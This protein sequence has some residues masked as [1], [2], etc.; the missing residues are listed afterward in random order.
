MRALLGNVPTDLIEVARGT[1]FFTVP[2]VADGTLINPAIVFT[3]AEAMFFSWQ[4]KT[5]LATTSTGLSYTGAVY[6]AINYDLADP[7]VTDPRKSLAVGWWV[8]DPADAAFDISASQRPYLSGDNYFYRIILNFTVPS[9]EDPGVTA[10]AYFGW[11]VDS[12]SSQEI[13]KA[14]VNFGAYQKQAPI[15]ISPAIGYTFTAS[16]TITAAEFWDWTQF[17]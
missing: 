1:P 7:L 9:N 16:A 13:G 17:P 8:H 5:W 15:Y 2:L 4:V 3:L 6:E 11:V 12:G 10:N 14:T